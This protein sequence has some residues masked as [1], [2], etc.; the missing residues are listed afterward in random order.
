MYRIVVITD[1][2]TG[3]RNAGFK[4]AANRAR[5]YK[6]LDRFD[7]LWLARKEFFNLLRSKSEMYPQYLEC[8]SLEE[9]A[10]V[11]PN[12]MLVFDDRV[13]ATFDYDVYTYVLEDE[14]DESSI[15][16]KEYSQ[17]DIEEKL[18]ELIDNGAYV[19]D[20]EERDA[21]D[22]YYATKRLAAGEWIK[23]NDNYYDLDAFIETF[24]N[25]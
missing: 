11:K 4:Y 20:D 14:S 2:Y 22:S 6:V 23:L 9:A 19:A 25:N 7:D 10:N 12:I 18:Q 15:V 16:V 24:L 8:E 17:N 5:M 1:P 3:S 13:H 21:L